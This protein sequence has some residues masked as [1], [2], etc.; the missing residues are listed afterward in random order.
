MR[1]TPARVIPAVLALALAG[2]AGC[3]SS[4][5]GSHTAN[6]KTVIKVALWNYDTT[7]E[8]KA[9]IDG[10]EAKYPNITVQPV[11][12]LSADYEQKI[13]AMLAGGD[14]TDVITVKNVTDYSQ[15]GTRG[16]LVDLT[17]AVNALPSKSSYAGLDDFKLSGKYYA[18]PYR[19]DFWVLYYNK[20][21]VGDTDMSHLTWSD[22]EALAKRLT[23]GSG[24]DK[25]Y[26]AYLHTWRS[27]VQAVASAQTGGD[28]LGPDY[29]WLKPQYQVALDLQQ[30]GAVMPFATA[31][32]QQAGYD[33]QF[34]TGKAALVPMGT[35]WAAALLSEKTQ[36]KNAIDWAIAP[37]P[38]VQNNGQ[39]VTFGSPTAFGVNKKAADKPDAEKFVEWASGPEGAAAVAKIGITPAYSDSSVMSTFFA[40]PGMPSDPVSKAAMEPTKVQLEMPVS[41]K[42]ADV[43]QILTEE[44]QLV[45]TGQKSVDAGVAEMESR[46]KNEVG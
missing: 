19:Q 34:T 29:S 30:A 23:T 9:L 14:K 38:Q 3:S 6:G 21:L 44:H 18:L 13:T 16:Q 25:V 10:F 27:V 8:F 46:V 20:K 7:P 15:Y 12:I 24:A 1:R 42:S 39:T 33:A 11:D 35:W 2:V 36:G 4:S 28:L 41:D 22:F 26:G 32:S 37:L 31:T 5:S 17:D 45:M 40:A 43:D